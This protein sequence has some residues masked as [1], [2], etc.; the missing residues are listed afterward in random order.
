MKPG[1]ANSG[2]NPRDSTLARADLGLLIGR[3]GLGIDA[4]REG[5]G[6]QEND[7]DEDAHRREAS[8]GVDSRYGNSNPILEG[9]RTA[10][11]ARWGRDEDVGL[12]MPRDAVADAS[13]EKAA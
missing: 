8:R 2:T 10:L 5:S 12:G 13:E 7:R 6:K 11:F 9:A 4:T 1:R 3:R